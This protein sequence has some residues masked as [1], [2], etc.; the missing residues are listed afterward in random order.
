MERKKLPPEWIQ[1]TVDGEKK[2]DPVPF[3]QGGVGDIDRRFP[4]LE[5]K[6]RGREQDANV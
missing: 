6:G 1:H 3:L 5:L 4:I 2:A